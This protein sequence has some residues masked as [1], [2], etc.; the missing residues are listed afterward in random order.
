M[1]ASL[2]AAAACSDVDSTEKLPDTSDPQPEP[3]VGQSSFVSADGRAG[4]ASRD[5]GD[6]NF[7][8]NANAPE[9]GD[10]ADDRTVE[11]GDIYRVTTDGKLLNLNS[12]RG[13]QVI[14]MADPTN[15][16]IIGK[17]QVSGY[18]VEMYQVGNRVYMLLNDW[19]GY[20]GN[21]ADVLP[22][23]YQGGLVMVV[24]I[25]NP[26]QPVITGRAEVPGY[27]QT[28]RLT[29]GGNQE[30]L[31]VVSQDWNAGGTKV[32]SF[33]VS[34]GGA[35]AAKTEIDLGGYVTDIQATGER[36]MVA[37]W[38][39]SNT[40]DRGS[41]V[42]V[43]DISSPDGVMVEGQSVKVKGRVANKFNM[44]M[45]NDVLRVVSGN[46]W[47]SATNTNHIQTFDA[48]DINNLTPI[49]EATFGDGENLFAT[50]FLGNKAFFVTYLRVDPFHAFEIT[51]D[52][53]VTE[54]SEF[55]VSGWNDFFKPVEQDT[56][57]VGIGIND[58]NGRKLAVSLYDVSD[59]T[60]ANPMLA[61]EEIDL[62]W[63]WSEANWDDRA[64]TVLEKGTS[65][66]A[67]DG[68]TLET[69]L[70]LL[71]FQ[72]WDDAT[73]T[74]I[75]AVQIFTFSSTTLTSRGVMRHDDPV[76]RSF[77]ADRTDNTVGNLSEQELKLHN[78]TNPD[79]P[80]ELG[81]VELAPDFAD[82]IV[83]GQYGLRR[84]NRQGY[85]SWWGS[86]PQNPTDEIQIVPLSGDV[87]SGLPVAQ[88]DIPAYAQ[89][90]KVGDTLVVSNRIYSTAETEVQ[91]WDLSDP[92]VPVLAG[93]ETY[94]DLPVNSYYDYYWGWD[95]FNCDIAYYPY[96]GGQYG[97]MAVGDSV[98]YPEI[99]GEQELAGTVHTT[100]YYPNDQY[101]ENCYDE[102]TGNRTDC[103]YYSGGIYCS[104]L[105]RVDGTQEAQVCSGS[106]YACT[107][108]GGET[109][110]T[111]VDASQVPHS[112]DNY[113][114]EQYRYWHYYNLHVLNVSNPAAPGAIQKVSMAQDEEAVSLMP[115]GDSLYIS[116]KKPVTVP[117]DARPYVAYQ[118]RQIDLSN[119]TPIVKPDVNVPGELIDVD[120]QTLITRDFLWGQNIVETSINKLKLSGSVA[121]LQG[122][123]RFQD[124]LVEQVHLDGAGR[125][126]VTERNTWNYYTNNGSDDYTLRLNILDLADA[127]LPILS[128]TP[129]DTWAQLK[130]A[131]TGRALFTVPG[132][133]LVVNLDDVTA[134]Y[135]QSY[136][137]VKGW[138]DGFQLADRTVYFA[139]GPYGVFTFDIDE[140]NL[141]TPNP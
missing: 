81:A 130:S 27:I 78:A 20:Y 56:R 61:R 1:A 127:T 44:D 65:V 86:T 73:D 122:V 14:D 42:S 99:V 17:V 79:M 21:R 46:D 94:A 107:V 85:Y 66:L 105:T 92:T 36:L 26:A 104:Q 28:S 50:L 118:M 90:T 18:P 43:I 22:T 67:E 77:V 124:K 5:N 30:A 55:I 2:L 63:G 123:R 53:M 37:R 70:V 101:Y 49:D 135:A 12:Y 40:N 16:E 132:G 19:R 83:H 116:Y 96:W 126:L 25:S 33:S 10:G 110:C 64:F 80:V 31:Y 54:K 68:M 103:S 109:D 24:D 95:C 72:G 108:T 137:P 39:W 140:T 102:Q 76:R 117:G 62:E 139:A 52:G 131:I 9:A 129:V 7:Q 8:N 29:R 3:E 23:A 93:T 111:E 75:S 89:L 58:E 121:T 134:P 45:Y 91:L 128:T 11:E 113:T 106:F 60:N 87:D 35:L 57:L 4:E 84:K 115:K 141:L 138:P 41:D 88:I 125:V 48:S 119:G 98:V 112:V 32:K 100:S 38:E 13:L 71:P 15:P 97:P 136:F 82:F 51:D 34:T 47:G 114:Y 6:D 59:L 69:G 120:G 74:Y 133:M